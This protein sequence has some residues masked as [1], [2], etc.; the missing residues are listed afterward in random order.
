MRNSNRL[1]HH[2]IRITSVDER[3]KSAS[4]FTITGEAETIVEKDVRETYDGSI[5][6][7]NVKGC[8]AKFFPVM[9]SILEDEL[10]SGPD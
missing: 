4:Y 1:A 6:G 9:L 8:F 5:R 3:E 7:Q 10:R 2:A